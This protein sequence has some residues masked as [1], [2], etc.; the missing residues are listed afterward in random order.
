MYLRLHVGTSHNRAC[1]AAASDSHTQLG[2]SIGYG[3]NMVKEGE[4]YGVGLGGDSIL[5]LG[6]SEKPPHLN[7][8]RWGQGEAS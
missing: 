7:S 8:Q 1:A 6:C 4:E 5:G 3:V 2:S